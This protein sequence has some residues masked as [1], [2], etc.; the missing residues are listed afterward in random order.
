MLAFEYVEGADHKIRVL[1]EG[2]ILKRQWLQHRNVWSGEYSHVVADRFA[3]SLARCED[4]RLCRLTVGA[5]TAAVEAGFV[6]AT[7]TSR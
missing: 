6:V 5:V 7:T 1:A 2:L 4:F 3:L